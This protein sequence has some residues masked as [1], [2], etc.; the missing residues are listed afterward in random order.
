MGGREGGAA[1]RGERSEAPVDGRVRLLDIGGDGSRGVLGPGAVGV[2][3]GEARARR[4]TRG[5]LWEL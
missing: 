1:G 4:G 3:G 5:Y 2:A